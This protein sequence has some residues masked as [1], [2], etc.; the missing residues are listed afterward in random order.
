MLQDQAIWTTMS[1]AKFVINYDTTTSGKSLS[2]E[3]SDNL[4]ESY[5]EDGENDDND[6]K[7]SIKM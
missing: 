4:L 3:T 6:A 1:L 7:K 5:E 2:A